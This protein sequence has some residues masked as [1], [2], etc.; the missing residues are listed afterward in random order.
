MATGAA[1]LVSFRLLDRL[2]GLTSTLV[3]AR[4]LAPTDYGLVA[5]AMSLGAFLELFGAFSFDIALIQRQG[6]TREHFDTAWTMN[7]IIGLSIAVAMLV[8]AVPAGKYYHQSQLPAV[9]CSLALA[10]AIQGFENIGIVNFRKELN[11]F[12]E[13]RFLFFKRLV[14]VSTTISLAFVLRNYWTLVIGI[15]VARVTGV[16]L[17]Y[18]LHP[19]RPRFS[20]AAHHDLLHFSKWM[21]FSNITG[22][23]KDR[24]GDF[25]IGPNC[26]AHALGIFN[27]SAELANMPAT[28]LTAPINRAVFPAYARLAHDKDALRAEYISV[29]SVVAL[30]AIPAAAGIA[31]TSSLIVPV[32]LGA[33]WLDAIPVLGILAFFGVTQ[34]LQS[35]AL[36]AYLALG[37]PDLSAWNNLVQGVLLVGALIPMT[38]FYGVIGGAL[39]FLLTGALMLPITFAVIFP[40]IGLPVRQF[41]QA[42][43]RPVAAA[44]IMYFGV[45]AFVRFVTPPNATTLMQIQVLLVSIVVGIAIYLLAVALLWWMVG[46]PEG[47]ELHIARRLPAAASRLSAKLRLFSPAK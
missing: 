26:G 34:I 12:Q 11:Y 20:L 17:S 18:F 6:A 27:V 38:K 13:V 5:M 41:L 31:A 23:I 1:W 43:W 30:I 8:L 9:V 46:R 45:Q 35:N 36:S 24:S 40:R 47:G 32:A 19:Y 42:T 3:L 15:L 14:Q 22:F 37:R 21:L 16:S 25:I 28:E 7:V 2:L 10:S 44:G 33:K 4:I 39:A 29:V